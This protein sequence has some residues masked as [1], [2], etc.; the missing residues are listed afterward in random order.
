[1]L[2]CLMT[3]LKNK[4][5]TKDVSRELGKALH[6][7]WKKTILRFS[8]LSLCIRLLLCYLLSRKD[9]LAGRENSGK[10]EEELLVKNFFFHEDTTEV[11]SWV[12]LSDY[13]SMG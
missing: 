3:A 8:V 2:S 5:K 9:V 1:M 6:C 12:M 7:T 10:R 11:L 13:S 4:H